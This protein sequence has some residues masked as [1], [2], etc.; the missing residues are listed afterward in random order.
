MRLARRILKLI[1]WKFEMNIQPMD[2]C[3][4]CV[5]PHTSNWDFILG[6]LASR[7]AGYKSGFLMKDTWFFFPLGYLLKAIGGIPV[8]QHTHTNVT[9]QVAEEY[10]R[11]KRLWVAIT[12]EG[13]RSPNPNWHKG[14]LYIAR[15]AQVPIVLAYF[16]Y[17]EKVACIDRIF[18][19]S[20]DVDADIERIK[21]YYAPRHAKHPENFVI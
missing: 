3:V 17:A 8:K 18:T 6:E 20:D 10:R 15:E 21:Q 12:P 4:I 16:D 5:A 13:T 11:R 9:E 7:S 1:G 19:P 2:K 14:F